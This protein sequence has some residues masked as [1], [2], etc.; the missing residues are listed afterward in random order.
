M[1]NHNNP[2]PDFD[3]IPNNPSPNPSQ[4]PIPQCSALPHNKTHLENS[5][6]S[7]RQLGALP[8][9]VGSQSQAQAAR[10]AGIDRS[11]LYRWL[12]DQDFRQELSRLR[13]ESAALARTELQASML[14]AVNVILDSTNSDNEIVRLRAARSLLNLGL[15]VNEIEKLRAEL[16]LLEKSL[17]SITNTQHPT[18]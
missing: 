7:P 11:T 10:S 12:Q 6:L 13:E 2:S 9:I 14:H 17:E 15:K 8:A 4:D 5:A 18:L 3:P 1:P 16:R